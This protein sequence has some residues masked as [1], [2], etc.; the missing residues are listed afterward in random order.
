MIENP[1]SN[2]QKQKINFNLIIFYQMGLLMSVLK[3]NG[4][5]RILKM[6]LIDIFYFIQ[7]KL[8]PEHWQNDGMISEK[9]PLCCLISEWNYSCANITY[10]PILEHG[11]QDWMFWERNP[12]Y[13]RIIT[14]KID[15]HGIPLSLAE[16]ILIWRILFLFYIEGECCEHGSHETAKV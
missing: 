1:W 5:F 15:F 16:L 10:K 3:N 7:Y 12:L 4:F 6:V 11:Q 13:C 2:L 9:N 8:I 14:V